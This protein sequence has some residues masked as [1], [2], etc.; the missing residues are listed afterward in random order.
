VFELGTEW[1]GSDRGTGSLVAFS[2]SPV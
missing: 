2:G 1:S